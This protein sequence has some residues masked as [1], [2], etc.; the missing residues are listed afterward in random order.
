MCSNLDLEKSIDNLA[1]K[2]DTHIEKYEN[3]MS[4]YER[5]IRAI[6]ED[7]APVL[8]IVRTANSSRRGVIWF[9]SLLLA[10]GAIGAMLVQCKQWL[11]K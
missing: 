8:E 7:I 3:T 4:T 5:D 6:K 11:T 1:E 2:V 10:L 9:A